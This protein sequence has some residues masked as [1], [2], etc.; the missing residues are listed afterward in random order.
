MIFD[1]FT[2]CSFAQSLISLIAKVLNA[3]ALAVICIV[4]GNFLGKYLERNWRVKCSSLINTLT[5]VDKSKTDGT[6]QFVHLLS[7]KILLR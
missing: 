1:K 5:L 3:V 4:Q 2:C 6:K 7:V